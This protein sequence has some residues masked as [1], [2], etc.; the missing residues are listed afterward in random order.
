MTEKDQYQVYHYNQFI[1]ITRCYLW[2]IYIHSLSHEG[3]DDAQIEWKQTPA[4]P[5][6]LSKLFIRPRGKNRQRFAK[7]MKQQRTAAAEGNKAVKNG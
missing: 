7:L 3:T 4:I 5:V 6:A 1:S 2:N